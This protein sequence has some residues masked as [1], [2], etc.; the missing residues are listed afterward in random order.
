MNSIVLMLL[1]VSI[2][3]VL[4]YRNINAKISKLHCGVPIYEILISDSSPFVLSTSGTKVITYESK[5]PIVTINTN[6]GLFAVIAG[7]CSIKYLGQNKATVFIYAALSINPMSSN[8]QM[9]S[10]TKNYTPQQSTSIA[11]VKMNVLQEAQIFGTFINCE[12]ND[13]FSITL[14]PTAST[15][16]K[17]QTLK[18][19]MGAHVLSPM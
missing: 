14:Q 11:F 13:K 15:D 2:A 3:I 5:T 6:P 10:L 4:I 8:G 18:I 16:P 9:Y 19:M 7:E 17:P 12:S 1:V